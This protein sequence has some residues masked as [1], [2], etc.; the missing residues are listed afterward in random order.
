MGGYSLYFVL[1]QLKTFRDNLFL[2]VY[3][4]LIRHY[5]NLGIYHT[6]MYTLT[7]IES[8]GNIYNGIES[9][10]NRTEY[11]EFVSNKTSITIIGLKSSKNVRIYVL[12]SIRISFLINALK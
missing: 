11:L 5:T 10:K 12:F 8:E 7:K 3:G 6:R 4:A 2:I 1:N 9:A